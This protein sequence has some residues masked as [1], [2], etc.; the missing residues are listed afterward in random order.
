MGRLSIDHVQPGMV[1]AKDA[2]TF[3]KQLLLPTGTVLNVKN[4]E[5]M[6]AWGVSE[7]GTEGCAEPSLEDVEA[8]LLLVPAL[9]AASLALDNR[10]KDVR[11]DAM[12]KEI[13]T[14]VKKQLLEEQR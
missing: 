3:R 5:L 7:A 1:L 13:L 2:H 12:M 10:F 11:E 4:I 8:R 6:K 14:I 9:A